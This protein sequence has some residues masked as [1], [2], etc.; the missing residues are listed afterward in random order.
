MLAA[1]RAALRAPGS[2]AFCAAGFVMRMPIAVYP[3]GIVL[4]IS[5]RTGHYGF[6]G[7][8]SA[9]Y[10]VGAVPGNPILARLV[11]RYGQGRLLVPATAVHVGA[12]ALLAVL[13]ETHAPNWTLPVPA[14]VAGFAYLSVGSLVR[15]RW[16]LALAGKP[17]LNTAYSLESILDELIF[18]V[19]PLLATVLATQAVPVLVLVVGAALV[20]S[21]AVWLSV[22]RATEPP[23]H[24][25]GEPR[26]ASAL[27]ERGMVLVTAAAVAMGALFA[28]AEV[29]IVAFCGQHG[30]RGAS[31][32]VLA[33]LAFGSG[34]AGFV[35]GSRPRKGD[36]VSRFRR[37]A[38]VFAVLPALFL[39]ATSIPALAAAAFVV[40]LGIA[41]TLI[42]AFGLVER[43]VAPGALTEGMAW[44]LTGL[45][46]GY[47]AGAALVGGIADHHGARTAFL[48]AV[49]SGLIMGVL[50][51]AL[52]RRLSVGVPAASQPAV[53]G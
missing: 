23:P 16:S 14:V 52:H 30:H 22:Q 15:A 24:Q 8:V 20:G 48:V 19:G 3:I 44:L 11:D 45:N 5:G 12:V 7:I 39:A 36:V 32:I 9:S 27:R 49:G 13:F 17:E 43:I 1:Y 31:G 2:A 21:G 18:V 51:L 35:Y 33:C 38:L 40:G 41:P 28:S 47:G 4:I 29:T 50:A 46:L 6:A 10:I 26:Q 34:V 25:A 53:V 37:Q 42:N